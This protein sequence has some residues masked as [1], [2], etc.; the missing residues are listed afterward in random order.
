MDTTENNFDYMSIINNY[1]T[2]EKIEY[3]NYMDSNGNLTSENSGNISIIL[4]EKCHENR[5]KIFANL[6]TLKKIIGI[7]LSFTKNPNISDTSHFMKLFFN[8]LIA[9][10][11]NVKLK[12]LEIEN[13]FLDS[14]LCKFFTDENLPE[15]KNLTFNF[16]I[17]LGSVKIDLSSLEK[18]YLEASQIDLHFIKYIV[19]KNLEITEN[20]K[21]LKKFTF[22]NGKMSLPL[23]TTNDFRVFPN[24]K[25]F[26][27]DYS[28]D[29]TEKIFLP[30]KMQTVALINLTTPIY[31]PEKVDTFLYQNNLMANFERFMNVDK[32]ISLINLMLQCPRPLQLIKF[33]VTEE[34]KLLSVID[35]EKNDV[36]RESLNIFDDKFSEL[37]VL[38]YE[39]ENTKINNMLSPKII[40]TLSKLPS[41]LKSL[42]ISGHTLSNDIDRL[43]TLEVLDFSVSQK[44]SEDFFTKFPNIITLSIRGKNPDGFLT[45]D[46]H[47]NKKLLLLEANGIR[48]I[49][50]KNLDHVVKIVSASAIRM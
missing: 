28:S 27:L 21:R 33:F 5:E 29:T 25:N 8:F 1:F 43:E 15:L 14:Y 41:N 22:K 17:F 39:T 16:V 49:N 36:W 38:K 11:T 26:Y 18:F 4:D 3:D 30:S 37:E 31:L 12:S 48:G 10:N 40:N 50:L 46:M 44:I 7:K 20:C 32:K 2:A 19:G 24:L 6:S 42:Y 34:I 13:T 9:K 45:F 47:L 35:K 23:L